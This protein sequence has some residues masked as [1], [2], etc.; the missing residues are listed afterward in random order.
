MKIINAKLSQL[1]CSHNF[2]G[3][4]ISFKCMQQISMWNYLLVSEP[5]DCCS[6]KLHRTG[7]LLPSG[8]SWNDCC[9]SSEEESKGTR[10]CGAKAVV[11]KMRPCA[12]RLT[13]WRA[14]S[15]ENIIKKIRFIVII[16][17]LPILRFCLL[18]KTGER[19]MSC[20]HNSGETG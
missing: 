20:S 2:G 8:K 11:L 15:R 16:M 19:K 6:M 12:V 13:H 5:C 1:K 3:N 9:V 18:L 10:F 7:S 17:V 4:N 14:R